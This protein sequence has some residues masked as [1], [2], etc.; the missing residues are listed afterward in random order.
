MVS[1]V[2]TVQIEAGSA[3]D[4][5]AEE[6]YRNLTVLFGSVAGE[7][8]LD[9]DFGIDTNVTDLPTE[10]AEAKLTA[11][12]VRKVNRYEPRARVSRVEFDRSGYTGGVFKPRV[13][14]QLV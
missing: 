5:M 3:N 13:V 4:T 1:V 7:Q 2:P 6:V 12:Y 11:E 14:I 10:S 8:A 9:R